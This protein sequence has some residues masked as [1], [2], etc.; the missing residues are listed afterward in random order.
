MALIFSSGTSG[1][2]GSHTATGP[3]QV[4]VGGTFGQNKLE[5]LVTADVAAEAPVA[6]FSAPGAITLQTA[7]GTTIDF[8]VVGSDT[9]E[10]NVSAI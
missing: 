10:I 8:N 3:T 9:S 5:V 7:A 2:T 1:T 6:N 4:I